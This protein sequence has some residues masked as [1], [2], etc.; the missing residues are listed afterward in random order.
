MHAIHLSQSN[1]EHTGSLTRFLHLLSHNPES[2]STNNYNF[3][4]NNILIAVHISSQ[5]AALCIL[6]SAP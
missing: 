5:S 1:V 3:D 2:L 6:L 4:L